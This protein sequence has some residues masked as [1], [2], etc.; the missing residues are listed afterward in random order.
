LSVQDSGVTNP[1]TDVNYGIC[2]G[3]CNATTVEKFPLKISV[4]YKEINA[5]KCG[6]QSFVRNHGHIA[7]ITETYCVFLHRIIT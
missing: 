1:I 6:S 5:R 4:I 3:I 2:Y 7:V